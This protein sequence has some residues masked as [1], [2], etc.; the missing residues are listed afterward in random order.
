[1]EIRRLEGEE[2]FRGELLSLVAFHYNTEDIE[3]TKEE[4][5]KA[6]SDDWGSF[7]E[8][9]ELMSHIVNHYFDARFDGHVIKNSGIGAVSTNPEFRGNGD[10]RHLFEKILPDCYEKGA[11]LSSLYPFNHGFYRK[12]GYETVLM[13]NSYT[14]DPLAFRKFQFDGWVKAWKEGDDLAPYKALYEKFA[15]RYNLAH[16]RLDREVKS[17][18]HGTYYKDRYFVYLIGDETG[19]LAYCAFKDM[20]VKN[21]E[22]SKESTVFVQDAAWDGLKGLTAL[23]AFFGRFTAD[24]QHVTI[25]MPTD[26]ELLYLFNN[27]YEIKKEAAIDH[28][29]RVVN[30]EEALKIMKKPEGAAFTV[31]VYGDEF[32]PVNNGTWYVS[33]EKAERLSD[34]A[35]ADLELDIHAFSQLSIGASDLYMS[36]LR[37]DVKVNGNENVLKEVFVRKPLF[38]ADYF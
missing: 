26:I 7:N 13:Q 38:L 24:Y 23:F 6:T 20:S 35:A 29:V 32:L 15:D 1:M 18:I 9:G 31:K 27:P 14:I 17:H 4:A 3:K 37:G 21:G 11:V 36:S 33:G 5:M 25:K 12:F 19:P 34:D 30:V 10:I 22:H 2:R 8:D 16:V 28:M